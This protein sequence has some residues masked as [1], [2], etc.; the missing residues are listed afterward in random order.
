M[1][2]ILDEMRRNQTEKTHHGWDNSTLYQRIQKPTEKWKK[3]QREEPTVSHWESEDYFME[4][5][6][7]S[8]QLAYQ[9]TITISLTQP[10][11]WTLNLTIELNPNPKPNLKPNLTPNL[12]PNTN[13]N[14]NLTPNLNPN[15]TLTLT[16]T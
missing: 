2:E 8:F 6:L 5:H 15:L 11:P 14:P 1:E 10:I 16:L 7:D 3:S 9:S 12:N 13:P 4:E